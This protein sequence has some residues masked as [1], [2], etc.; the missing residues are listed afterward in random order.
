LLNPGVPDNRDLSTGS[1]FN[2]QNTQCIPVVN[3]DKAGSPS[4]NLKKNKYFSKVSS[5]TAGHRYIFEK[6][7]MNLEYAA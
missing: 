4:L 5:L 1:N 7:D 2:P 3:P 6:G